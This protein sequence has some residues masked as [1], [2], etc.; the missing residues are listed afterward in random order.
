MEVIKRDGREVPFNKTK[1]KQAIEKAM[2]ATGIVYSDIAR[3]ISID[4]ENYFKKQDKDKITIAEIEKYVFDRL[5]HYGQTV[6]AR[7]YEN[8]RTV[9]EYRKQTFDTDEKILGLIRGTDKELINE[10]SNKNAKN[11]STQ[12]DLM[13]GEVS[14][15][16]VRRKILPAEFVE[17]HDSGIVHW[18]DMDYSIQPILNC[19][20]INMKDML[21]NGTVIN[22][23]GIDSPNSF[24]TACNIATQIM[25]QVASGQYGRR[26]A[27]LEGNF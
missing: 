21:D 6:T 3:I 8:Y 22:G 16:I 24:K 18:H 17:A 23:H 10:N 4:A 26:S 12:R 5:C 1:I 2:K 13:A 9:Q 25:A 14:K 27:A 19:L 15:S 11:A 20:L 7:A